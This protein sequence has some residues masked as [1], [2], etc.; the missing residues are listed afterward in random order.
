[1]NITFKPHIK[2]P[3]VNLDHP[4][5]ARSGGQVPFYDGETEKQKNQDTLRCN[6]ES[7]ELIIPLRHVNKVEKW[8]SDQGLYSIKSGKFLK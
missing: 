4:L 7:G 2:L 6:V 1:M 5:N 8:L 3:I